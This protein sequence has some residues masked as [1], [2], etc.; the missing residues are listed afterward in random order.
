MPFL[1]FITHGFTMLTKEEMEMNKDNKNIVSIEDRIPKLKE[2]RKKKA[3]RRLVFYMTI[4]FILISIIVYLQSPLS[5]V[6]QVSVHNNSF[7]TDEE[8]MEISGLSGEPNIWSIDL[9]QIKQNL[10]DNQVI[11][12]VAVDR[13]LPNT[14]EIT[15]Q[16]QEII[17]FM[18]EGTSFYPVL[19]SGESLETAEYDSFTGEAP[20][21]IGFT[22]EEYL[23]KIAGELNK[24]PID[25]L[26][27]ISEIH[28]QPEEDS[29]DNI[30]L[31]MNDGFVV[32]GAVR[33]IADGMSVY[34]S[35]VSQLD[36]E[37]KGIIHMGIGVYFEAFQEEGIEPEAAETAEET[38]E[39]ADAE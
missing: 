23:S 39:S 27:L 6:R 3:N 16:E 18:E 24:L 33:D 1:S 31:Y 12:E 37:V 5:E 35:V 26:D 29:Q 21:L 28:W 17:G 10:E 19:S 22:D 15:V 9:E 8:I 2:A 32:K 7:I 20:L 30:M 25:I 11:E 4:F 38:E 14:V 34:P 36:P 13:K